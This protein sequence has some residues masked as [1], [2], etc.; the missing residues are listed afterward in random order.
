MHLISEIVSHL[1][2]VLYYFIFDFVFHFCV[3]RPLL[4]PYPS[5]PYFFYFVYIVFVNVDL[6]GWLFLLRGFNSPSSPPLPLSSPTHKI[7]E[8]EQG[9]RKRREG[10]VKRIDIISPVGCCSLSPSSRLPKPLLLFSTNR[11][12]KS[13]FSSCLVNLFVFFCL[14]FCFGKVCNS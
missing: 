3:W 10:S 6:F 1:Q 4:F 8:S 11:S 14:F 2:L 9:L 13:L 12:R 5:A 7:K